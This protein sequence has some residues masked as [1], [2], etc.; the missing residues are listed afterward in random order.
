LGACG[1][2]IVL[3]LE[4]ANVP[5]EN[6]EDVTHLG[7]SNILSMLILTLMVSQTMGDND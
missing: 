7:S 4:A 2:G 6:D 1:V 3:A 5:V